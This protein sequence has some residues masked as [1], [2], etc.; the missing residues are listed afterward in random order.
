MTAML[1]DP[2]IFNYVI[3]FLYGTNA[4]RWVFAGQWADVS[5]WIC[6]LGITAT[7][8]FGYSR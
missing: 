1:F 8:T 5:Y 2:K 4:L 3:M 7:V 6:A